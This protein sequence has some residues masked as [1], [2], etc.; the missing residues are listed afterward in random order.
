M[1][2]V[3]TKIA[4]VF[5]PL[6]FIGGLMDGDIGIAIGSAVFWGIVYVLLK[7]SS[8]SKIPIRTSSS[9]NSNPSFDEYFSS[10]PKSQYVPHELP[11]VNPSIELDLELLGQEAANGKH[12]KL[13]DKVLS[14][15][16]TMEWDEATFNV[17]Q[18]V[19][20]TKLH[21]EN[22]KVPGDN[23]KSQ[24][25]W[26]AN[27][28]K[29]LI[30]NQK[31]TYMKLFP[32]LVELEKKLGIPLNN[33]QKRNLLFGMRLGMGLALIENQSSKG[34]NGFIHP[35]IVNILANPIVMKEEIN[36]NSP[37][38]WDYKLVKK[39]EILTQLSMTIGYFHTKYTAD[40]PKEVLSEVKF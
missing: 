40:S 19:D 16:K 34:I 17:E 33:E 20:L 29:Q 31:E 1:K 6:G 14:F 24:N 37:A 30:D 27:R 28:V 38:D 18:H 4:A 21:D 3:F 2:S 10:V 22:I 25:A 15:S 23:L 35:S 9:D 5:V 11:R 7:R 8:Q 32:F 39:L 26:M 12:E 36:R 13:L